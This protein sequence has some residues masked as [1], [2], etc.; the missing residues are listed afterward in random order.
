[1][2][3]NRNSG[4][5]HA[6]PK[7]NKRR[8]AAGGTPAARGGSNYQRQ[9]NSKTADIF[10]PQARQPQ[11]GRVAVNP[12]KDR[13]A[14]LRA[15]AQ[16]RKK[17][18][19]RRK[20]FVYSMLLI[21]IAGIGT[22]LSLTV[23][24]HIENIDVQGNSRY[25]AQKI[26]DATGI[27][28]QDNL[29][30]TDVKKAEKAVLSAFPYVKEAA[31]KRKP[32]PPG[33]FIEVT[34][35]QAAFVIKQDSG[36]IL[37]DPDCRVLETGRSVAPPGL[38]AIIGA[39]LA[40]AQLG[41]TVRFKEAETESVMKKITAA[42]GKCGIGVA[43]SVD[44]STPLSERAAITAIDLSDPLNLRL[45]FDGRLTLVL[46]MPTDLDYKL[47]FAKSAI[48]KLA[49]GARGTLDLSVLKKATYSP[50]RTQP[51][52]ADETNAEEQTQETD[53]DGQHTANVTENNGENA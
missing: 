24:F 34:E 36:F 52:L 6:P 51:E 16:K 22:V 7:S 9:K 12:S 40:D 20:I 15:H 29:F 21:F 10:A 53:A 8:T 5:V 25:S 4:G 19:R 3:M 18:I 28:I 48:D 35:T 14:A 26:I 23:F 42:V 33:I 1:M 31:V 38:P 45:I 2:K 37:L 27:K 43:K 39:E 13:D 44:E 46:G 11:R 50:D 41:Q 17:R 32:F 49:E 47:E 30:I